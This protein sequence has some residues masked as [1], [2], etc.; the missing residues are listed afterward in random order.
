MPKM[1]VSKT[2]TPSFW[3]NLQP[4]LQLLINSSLST[5]HI[6]I[7]LHFLWWWGVSKNVQGLS[8]C[9]PSKVNLPQVSIQILKVDKKCKINEYM[10]STQR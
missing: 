3:E 10:M 1:A 5:H 9:K 6:L 2:Y 8:P 4:P 7:I